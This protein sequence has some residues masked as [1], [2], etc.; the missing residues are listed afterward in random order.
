MLSIFLG[1]FL[2]G[3]SG[4]MAP[5]PL[6]AYAIVQ[7]SRGWWRSFFLILGHVL[8]EAFLVFSLLMGFQVFLSNK[9]FVRTL[10]VLGGFFLLYMG[11]SLLLGRSWNDPVTLPRGQKTRFLPLMGA[12]ISLSNPYFLLWWVAVGGSFLARA[13]EQLL[14]G[15]IAFY[16]GHIL[17]DISWYSFI[18][19]V[20]QSLFKPNWRKVYSIVLI[21]SSLILLGFGAYF[22]FSG[23]RL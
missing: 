10:S 9:V 12:L 6:M 17:S 18:G 23:F 14:A 22:V 1:S 19:V 13:K 20:G 2:V 11:M 3:L 8:L 21:A 16:F 5:G 7:S 15:V 4:A